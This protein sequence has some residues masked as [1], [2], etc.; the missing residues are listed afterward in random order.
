ENWSAF[1]P[2]FKELDENVEYEE[3]ESEFDIEDEDKSEPEQTGADAAEDEEVDVTTVD[4]IVAFCS[5]DEELEDNRALLYVPIAPEVEDPEENPFG[6]PPDASGLSGA[7]EDA[8]AGA[9]K[10]QR[11]PCSEMGPAKKKAR[12]TTIELKGVPSD[13]VHPLLGVKG[14]GKSKKK[15]AGR[16]KGS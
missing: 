3:R 13:E 9:D 8:G 4:P 14:D 6:P 11:Q 2:D 10:K 1:A 12:T 15:T 16:P 5:S 7:G